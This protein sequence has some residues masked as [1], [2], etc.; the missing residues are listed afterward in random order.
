MDRLELE[1]LDLGRRLD[2]PPAPDLPAAVRARLTTAP[3]RRIRALVLAF[4]LLALALGAAMAV[5]P[6]R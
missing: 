4:V 3:R 2:L 5:P 6:A 1:L